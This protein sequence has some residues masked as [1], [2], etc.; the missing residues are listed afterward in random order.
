VIEVPVTDI[1]WNGNAF[2]FTTEVQVGGLGGRLNG[3][4]EIGADGTVRGE[5]TLPNGGKSPLGN[6]TGSRPGN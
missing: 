5:F 3:S 2:T 4:G 6:F 1:T